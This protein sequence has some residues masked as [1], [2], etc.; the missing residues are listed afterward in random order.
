MIAPM[1]VR[2]ISSAA[3]NKEKNKTNTNKEKSVLLKK[4][5]R[6]YFAY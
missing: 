3:T 2:G 1:T 5:Q 6:F 4:I